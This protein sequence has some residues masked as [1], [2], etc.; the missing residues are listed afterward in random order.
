[1]LNTPAIP[2]WAAAAADREGRRSR[3]LREHAWGCQHP[4][5]LPFD[6]REWRKRGRISTFGIRT[7]F[8][9]G[10]CSTANI[11]F[12]QALPS[13]LVSGSRPLHCSTLAV[14]GLYDFSFKEL[15]FTTRCCGA[16]P[17]QKPRQHGQQF[18]SQKKQMEEGKKKKKMTFED[19]DFFY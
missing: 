11:T 17:V 12:L 3:E 5:R 1:M 10:S 16:A 15:C 8:I 18:D 14:A 6:I 9:R 13:L 7:A 19:P 2:L 4:K